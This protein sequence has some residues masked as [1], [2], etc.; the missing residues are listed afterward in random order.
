MTSHQIERRIVQ[1]H[2]ARATVMP[3]FTPGQWFECDVAEVT[4]AGYLVEYEIKLSKSDF[5]ADARKAERVRYALR[6]TGPWG[7]TK[8]QRLAARDSKGPSRFYF[9]TPAGLLLPS[10]IP[11]WAGWMEATEIYHGRA[12][13]LSV[14]KA[15]PRLHGEKA[16]SRIVEQMRIAAYYRFH[17]RAPD[18]GPEPEWAL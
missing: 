3:R 11:E 14:M 10:Q 8:H 7:Q 12:V 4:D 6:S 1:D 16:D 15:A 13:S 17:R 5:K 9:V 2:F 18:P